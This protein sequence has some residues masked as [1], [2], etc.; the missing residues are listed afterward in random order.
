MA[1]EQGPDRKGGKTAGLKGWIYDLHKD[2]LLI[3]METVGLSTE[4][5]LDVLRQRMSRY[6]DDHPD[7]FRASATA[8]PATSEPTTTPSAPLLRP[9]RLVIQP[10][11]PVTR[12]EDDLP[13]AKIMS[14]MR[15]WGVQFDGKD[16]WGFLERV[17]ELRAGYGFLDHH[18]L[19]GLPE[20]LKGDALLWCRNSRDAWSN[21]SDFLDDFKVTYLPPRYR[22]HLIRE[23]RDRVQKPD[24]PYLRYA[25]AVLSLMRRA[26]NF[27][28]D[29]R[30]DQLYDNM[31][32]EYQLQIRRDDIYS[33]SELFQR[34]AEFERI[35]E[36]CRALRSAQ[37]KSRET[38]V[39]AATYDRAECCWRCKQRGHTRF[40]C[41]R[42]PRKFCSQCGKDGVMTRDC[43]PPAG[44]ETR[45]GET[46]AVPRSSA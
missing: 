43:H 14:Q 7:E 10:A 28:T 32:P 4:G 3:E 22:S 42:P 36:R 34:A 23:I 26:G 31:R 13:P 18:I 25:T 30:I 27:S 11:P 16:P 15:K 12:A 17:E 44:N 37:A 9:P 21:W 8:P 46:P 40:D 6:V 5:N 33:T 45:T 24:E 35:Q 1:P 39:A 2:E 38:T 41:R 20:L 19:L 29:D